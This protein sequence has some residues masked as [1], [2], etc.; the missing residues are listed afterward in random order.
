[1]PFVVRITL[2]PAFSIFS[3][4][5]L[6]MSASLQEQYSLGI[7]EPK[8]QKFNIFSILVTID[9]SISEANKLWKNEEWIVYT[10]V[11][12]KPKTSTDDEPTFDE[13]FLTLWDL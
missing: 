7:L 1:M 13:F 12:Q 6:V 2:A 5:S 10:K 11:M 9:Y 8:R 3:I 4:L